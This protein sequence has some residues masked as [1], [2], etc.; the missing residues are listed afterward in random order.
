M[1]FGAIFDAIRKVRIRSNTHYDDGGW[2]SEKRRLPWVVFGGKVRK[3]ICIGK[4]I[5]VGK[6]AASGKTELSSPTIN[7]EPS[8]NTP[9]A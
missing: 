6:K 9:P 2:I 7:N 5:C 8:I 1:F 4:N 3:N